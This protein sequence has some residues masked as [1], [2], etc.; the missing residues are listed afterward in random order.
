MTDLE[1]L[2]REISKLNI[3]KGIFSVPFNKDLPIQKATLRPMGE[4]FQIESFSKTQAFHE[5]V[6]RDELC[7]KIC[8]LLENSFRQTEIFTDEYVYGLK[9]SSKGKLLHNR[10]RNTDVKSE[11]SSHNR[12][13]KHIIDLDNAP[14]VFTDIG[15]IGKD[16]KI[17]NSKYDKYKQICRFVEFIDDVVKK[18]PREEYN[19]IDFGCGKSYLT[20]V[21]YYYMTEIAGKRVNIVGLDLKK[22]VIDDCNA[23]A[24]KYGYKGLEFIC[25]E[26]EH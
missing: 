12:E 18:D 9:I 21:C 25:M 20:F 1:K 8:I 11:S 4:C 5:N 6:K 17:I 10:R 19:I 26:V 24:L 22:K 7:S 15:I 23:L 2:V 13:K 14:P 16:G 3:I